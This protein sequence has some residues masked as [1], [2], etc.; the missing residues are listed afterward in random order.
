MAADAWVL[1]DTGKEKIHDST[2]A[3]DGGDTLKCALVLSTYTPATTH[4]TWASISSNEHANGNGYSTGGVTTAG[5]ITQSSGTVTFD[6]ADPQWTAS[7][8]SIVT[9]YAVLYNS[10]TGDLICYSLLDNSPADVTVTDTNILTLQIDA[11]GVY[12]AA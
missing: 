1:Y 3:L 10:T 8:G 2:F 11:L 6:I 5:T 7:G 12:Q 9:R 4:T